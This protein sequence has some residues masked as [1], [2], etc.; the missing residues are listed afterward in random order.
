[1]WK[2]TKADKIR[3]LLTLKKKVTMHEAYGPFTAPVAPIRSKGSKQLLR[4][5]N[6]IL[7]YWH[8]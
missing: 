6:G 1:M 4:N 5:P 2:N 8:A 7:D 3:L